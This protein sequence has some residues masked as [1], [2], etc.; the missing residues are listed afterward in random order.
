MTKR[1]KLE[2]VESVL[3]FFDETF[4]PHIDAT[5]DGDSIFNDTTTREAVKRALKI[6]RKE[7]V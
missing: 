2:Y 4:G 6:I 7:T 1:E 3:T 5:V